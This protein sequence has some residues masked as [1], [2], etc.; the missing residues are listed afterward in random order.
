MRDFL[1]NKEELKKSMEFD[2]NEIAE[3]WDKINRLLKDIQDGI[4][5]KPKKNEDILFSVKKRILRLID[6]E[7]REKYSLQLP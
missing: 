7:I 2:E 4:Q 5:R 1:C 3:K 6:K